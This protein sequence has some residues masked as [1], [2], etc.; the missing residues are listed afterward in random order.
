MV[1]T[2]QK[3]QRV[4]NEIHKIFR[5]A[6]GPR[7]RREYMR[8]NNINGGIDWSFSLSTDVIVNNKIPASVIGC[9]GIA[10]VFSTFAANSGLECWVIA[11]A[12]Y[13]DWQRAKAGENNIINGHQIIAVKINGKL[14]AFDPGRPELTLIDGEIAPGRFLK[15]VQGR[16]AYLVCGII[17]RD[18]FAH[19]DTYQKLRN[20]YASG[21]MDNSDFLITPQI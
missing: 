14:C 1:S 5:N 4:L 18:E 13:N 11:T 8:E 3:I 21:S 6:I 9:T 17:P 7:N 16:P 12:E 10:K 20:L 2:E 15:A 19:C